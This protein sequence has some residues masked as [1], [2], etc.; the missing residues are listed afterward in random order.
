MLVEILEKQ[1]DLELEQYVTEI[2]NSAIKRADAHSRQAKA[3]SL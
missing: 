2:K 1:E 3:N